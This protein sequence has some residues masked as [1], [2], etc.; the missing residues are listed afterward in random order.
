MTY[1]VVLLALALAAAGCDQ[2]LGAGSTA[3]AP[4]PQLDAPA[5][6]SEP[7][8][9]FSA[10]NDA[11]TSATGELTVS[12]A[13]Q[14]PDDAASDVQEVLTLRAANGLT[15]EAQISGAVSPATQ[16][17]GQTLRALLELPVEAPQVLV[18]RVTQENRPEGGGGLC[19]GDNTAFVVLWEP[20][21]PGDPV[22]KLL[23]VRDAAPGSA[24]ARACTMLE[25]RRA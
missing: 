3:D 24:G 21:G 16:V 8:R 22:M 25:Y 9:V 18:Y 12:I 6:I 1:R 13:Q 5:P 10:T 19:G 17:Q 2:Q 15:V 20:S 23:G 4:A 7:S 14:L 11:A